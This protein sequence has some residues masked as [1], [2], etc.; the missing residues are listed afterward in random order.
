M[1][2]GRILVVEDEAAIARGLVDCLV[3]HGHQAEHCADGLAGLAR[4]CSGAFDLLLLDVML[5]GCDGFEICRQARQRDGQVAICLLT[6]KGGEADI[7]AGF[8]AGADDYVCKPFSVA[9]LMARVEALLRRRGP[10]EGDD[11]PFTLGRL[12]IDPACLEARCEGRRVALKRRDVSILRLLQCEAGRI[13]SRR[14]L[15]QQA[16]E[17]ERPELLETRSVDMH[18]VKLRR[19]LQELCPDEDFIETIRGEGYRLSSRWAA[20]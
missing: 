2:T 4:A 3:F 1:T 9:Q 15:L 14:R 7:L 10:A 16:W 8:A 11:T 18:L 6:A 5:P 13:V 12:T 19:R 20:S 17:V